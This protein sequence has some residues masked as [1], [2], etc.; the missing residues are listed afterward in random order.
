MEKQD[1]Q[2]K[3]S[4]S[5][6]GSRSIWSRKSLRKKSP[7]ADEVHQHVQ[8]A[9]IQRQPSIQPPPPQ[10][11][12]EKTAETEK[13]TG[14]G[15]SEK[16]NH[17]GPLN[18]PSRSIIPDPLQ[19]SPLWHIKELHGAVPLPVHRGRYPLHNPFGPRWY[20]NHH[21]IPPAQP[22][23]KSFFSPSFPSIPPAQLESLDDRSRALDPNRTP[24]GSPLP[25]PTSSQT[26]ITDNGGRT[27]SRKTSQTAPDPVDLL[28]VT[29]PWGTNW[30]HQSPYDVGLNGNS[31]SVDNDVGLLLHR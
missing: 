30:H 15:T 20:R 14:L 28:D 31:N 23:P 3:L 9:A 29:D 4:R 11:Q 25:T 13:Q 12:I 19:G 27:R 6:P 10:P 24:S 26:G 18:M 5:K 21:L 7:T 16:F 17:V 2:R 8:P 22:R 1:L